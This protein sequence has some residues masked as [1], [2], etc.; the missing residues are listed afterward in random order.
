MKERL[1]LLAFV[2]AL[3]VAFT[4][5]VLPWRIGAPSR[6]PGATADPDGDPCDRHTDRHAD[7]D[8]DRHADGD[9]HRHTHGDTDRH[10]DGD[11]TT[12]HTD[13]DPTTTHT[14]GHAGPRRLHR[15]R[16]QRPA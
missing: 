3:V 8:P 11:T 1:S 4:L 2:V 12:R 16:P 10:A 13:G 9:T 14:D 7:G 6:R 15:R 5:L